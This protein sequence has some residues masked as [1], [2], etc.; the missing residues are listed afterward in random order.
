MSLL[1][2]ADRSR[3]QPEVGFCPSR[4][5][6]AM[7]TPAAITRIQLV[8]L[9][10]ALP[11]SALVPVG[12]LR[13]ML[14]ADSPTE[15]LST[16]PGAALV[17]DFSAKEVGLALG[18]SASTVRRWLEEG[19]FVGAYKLR[20][21]SWRVPADS[22]EL[23]KQAQVASPPAALQPMHGSLSDWRRKAV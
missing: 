19:L 16:E 14:T 23:F 10:R 12:W 18:R 8:A 17:H 2:L 6:L 5:A 9:L 15:G 3:S 7:T 22:M 20:G 4:A 1:L 11:D 13:G 21:K